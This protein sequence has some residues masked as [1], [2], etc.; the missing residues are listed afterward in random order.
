M[1]MALSAFFF[2]WIIVLM[3]IVPTRI[4]DIA[5]NMSKTRKLLEDIKEL[6]ERERQ[7]K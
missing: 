3:I 7:V 5:D 2:I 6:L 1:A 4:G